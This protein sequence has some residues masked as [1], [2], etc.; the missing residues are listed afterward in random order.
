MAVVPLL[1]LFPST[2]APRPVL[3]C[4]DIYTR[5]PPTVGITDMVV[6]KAILG[7]KD[8]EVVLERLGRLTEDEAWI[9][10]VQTL[11]LSVVFL[12]I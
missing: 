6:K 2:K 12:R 9:T 4:L 11:E 10:V 8:T 3:N 1:L 5:I 7:E